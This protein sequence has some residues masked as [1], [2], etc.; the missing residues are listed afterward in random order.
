MNN[1][2]QPWKEKISRRFSQINADP[3]CVNPRIC[4]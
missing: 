1:A 3:I 2:I 4:G